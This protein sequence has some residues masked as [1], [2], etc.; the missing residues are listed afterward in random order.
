MCSFFSGKLNLC[1]ITA[2]VDAPLPL[3]ICSPAA[4]H[5][6]VPAW[7]QNARS[8]WA[9]SLC[10]GVVVHQS[11]C[12]GAYGCSEPSPC[13]WSVQRHLLDSL[14]LWCTTALGQ[15]NK[16]PIF[17][18]KAEFTVHFQSNCIKM[19]KPVCPREKCGMW[20]LRTPVWEPAG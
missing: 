8:L 16:I 12:A 15:C 2:A 14:H 1:W 7:P 17:P 3:N 10:R 19:C 9:R 6:V 18:L 20:P 13:S 4:A 5:A 11:F